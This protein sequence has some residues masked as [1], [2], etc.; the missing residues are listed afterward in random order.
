[1]GQYYVVV[2]FDKRE[3]INPFLGDDLTVKSFGA[4]RNSTM[5]AT[6]LLLS[7]RWRGD[8]IGIVGDYGSKID[9]NASILD[10]DIILD[11][12]Q[13]LTMYFIATRH[14]YGFVDVT[15]TSQSLLQLNGLYTPDNM[16]ADSSRL[17]Y[18][19]VI[20]NHTKQQYIRG[21]AFG[22][23][24]NVGE[25]IT[26]GVGGTLNA[27]SILLSLSHRF[28]EEAAGDDDIGYVSSWMG[29]V[30]GYVPMDE[31]AEDAQNISD[32]MRKLMEIKYHG[33]E[34]RLNVDGSVRRSFIF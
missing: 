1:M 2:N 3:F 33:I 15:R 29:D 23:S 28:G 20:F 22:D 8:R 9:M 27:L 14:A 21:A 26:G 25:F 6:A 11:D 19:G 13:D 12:S 16:K 24:N 5:T 30:I 10:D 32:T 31:V 7:G 34:Y 17:D 4:S 18:D